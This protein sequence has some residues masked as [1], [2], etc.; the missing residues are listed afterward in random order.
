MYDQHFTVWLHGHLQTKWIMIQ[1]VARAPRPTCA[2]QTGSGKTHTLV[3]V[4]GDEAQAGVV[5]RAA[6]A[7]CQ[8]IAASA[9]ACTFAVSLSATEIYCERIRCC[10]LKPGAPGADHYRSTC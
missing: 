7:L 1:P 9:Q 5:P 4:C 6:Q 3:G 10:S 8:G 2:G